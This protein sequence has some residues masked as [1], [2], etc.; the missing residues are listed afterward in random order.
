MRTPIAVRLKP[1]TAADPGSG[2]LNRSY[3][4]QGTRRAV[5]LRLKSDRDTRLAARERF[6]NRVLLVDLLGRVVF[7][8][9]AGDLLAV[10]ENVERAPP[11]LAAAVPADDR[12][13]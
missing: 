1:D 9:L 12:R 5:G 2:S 13:R 3:F 6:G 11:P 7:E 10:D 4:D 8:R